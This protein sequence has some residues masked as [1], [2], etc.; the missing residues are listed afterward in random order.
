VTV[1][2]LGDLCR[3]PQRHD[4]ERNRGQ[5]LGH[6]GQNVLAPCGGRATAADGPSAADLA[7]LERQRMHPLGTHRRIAMWVATVSQ[8]AKSAGIT[9]AFV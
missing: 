4:P 3:Q 1:N 6:R 9:S 7:A 5:L 2:E 8:K